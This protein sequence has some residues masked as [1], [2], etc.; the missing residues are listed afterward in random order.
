MRL[1]LGAS[2]LTFTVFASAGLALVPRA[3]AARD[4]PQTPPVATTE[5]ALEPATRDLPPGHPAIHSDARTA[6]TST[7]AEAPTLHWTAPVGWDAAASE[8][9]IRL[10][11]YRSGALELTVSRAGGSTDANLARWVGQFDQA[12]PDT[13][14]ESTVN[15][16]HVSTLEVAGTYEGG[17]TPGGSEHAHPRWALLGAVVETSGPSY[18][19]KLVGPDAEVRA[20]HPAFDALLRSVGRTP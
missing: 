9:P 12:G 19:F 16:L 17:M 20:A 4:V 15:G 3:G 11:T 6:P 10:A 1:P 2:L 8:S 5:P 13:R 14:H 7:A 18:F